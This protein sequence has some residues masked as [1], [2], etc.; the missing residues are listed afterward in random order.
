MIVPIAA[1]QIATQDLITFSFVR[2]YAMISPDS[3]PGVPNL[4]TRCSAGGSGGVA[5]RLS[6]MSTTAVQDFYQ[7]THS[8]C[9]IGPGT[10]SFTGKI[11]MCGKKPIDAGN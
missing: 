4:R 3:W 5:R 8:A 10:S 9:R 7:Y 6:M 2:L 1:D 11:V